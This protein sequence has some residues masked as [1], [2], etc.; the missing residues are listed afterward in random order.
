MDQMDIKTFLTVV[1][2][3]NFSRAAELLYITQ[4]TVSYHISSLEKEL[5]YALLVR[6]QGFRSMELTPQGMQ[7]IPI[8]EQ[9]A[10][11]WDSSLAIRDS[12]YKPVLSVGATNRL[13]SHILPPFFHTF[14]QEHSSILLDIRSYHSSEIV[15]LIER[16]ELDV[17]FISTNAYSKSAVVTPF[18]KEDVVMIC[19]MGSQYTADAVHPKD[20]DAR[21]EIRLASNPEIS[22][23]RQ[24][25]WDNASQPYMYVD[26]A[27]M[28][29]RYLTEPH[30]WS[31]CP[32]S[33]ALSLQKQVP[34]EIHPFAVEVPQQM[35]YLILH[36][37]PK[38]DKMPMLSAC[39]DL[40]RRFYKDYHLL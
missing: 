37:D 35:S 27:T 14:L 21:N 11:L 18:L 12:S 24:R 39:K 8:A 23:W 29:V 6:R 26:T 22:T 36:N 34:I 30:L 13:N 28:A 40:L 25:N 31:L 9:M 2:C 5:G 19:G 4:T 3:G 7:F 17:G 33:V 10:S 15:Q 20:L 38:P 1:R 16:K 32:Y